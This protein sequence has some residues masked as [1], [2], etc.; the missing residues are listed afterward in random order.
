MKEYIYITSLLKSILKNQKPSEL[1]DGLTFEGIYKKSKAHHISGMVFYGIEILEKKPDEKLFKLWRQDRDKAI[2][3]NFNQLHEYDLL[4]N[5]FNEN[6]IEYIPLK[7]II[8]KSL[9]PSSDMRYMCDIDVITQEGSHR[10]LRDIMTKKGY[11]IEHFDVGNH[12]AYFKKP[13]M[14]IEI[15]RSLFSDNTFGGKHFKDY[16][17][18]PFECAEKVGEYKFE[19]KKTYFFLHLLTHAAKHYINGGVGLRAFM[20]IWLYY[21][22]FKSEIDLDKIKEIL[23]NSEYKK[24]CFDFITISEMWFGDKKY[25]KSFDEMAH[26]I[27]SGGAFGTIKSN[28][29]NEIR[30]KGKF[31]YILTSLFPSCKKLSFSYPILKKIPILY[32]FCLILRLVTKP[33]INHKK[34]WGR[35]KGIFSYKK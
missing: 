4:E 25:D 24:L 26:Y 15:H 14:S 35:I 33:F 31:R 21:E 6:K 5:D 29:H 12:D 9:Y 3:R 7:G 20:D 32:P 34:T 22:N 18:N 28:T 2:A 23:R 30:E 10:M 16:L 8:L 1:P 13:V 19:L 17:K 27:C 11:E